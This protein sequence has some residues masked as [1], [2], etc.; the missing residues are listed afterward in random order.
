M[1]IIIYKVYLIFS[2]R[3]LKKKYAKF[4][5]PRHYFLKISMIALSVTIMPNIL[6]YIWKLFN[7]RH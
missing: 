7:F 1:S 3:I 5:I 6:G 4:G 2:E